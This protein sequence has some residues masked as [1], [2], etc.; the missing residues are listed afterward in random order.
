MS[1]DLRISIGQ[2]SDKGA[3][4]INQDFHGALVPEQPA[5]GMKGIAIAIADG[6][7]SSNVSQVASESAIKSFMMDYS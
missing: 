1:H 2:H 4:E 6:I 3:K 5:L 7:S